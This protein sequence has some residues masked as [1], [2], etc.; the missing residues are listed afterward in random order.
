M[1][2]WCLL[3][4]GIQRLPSRRRHQ[5]TGFKLPFLILF[6]P[7]YRQASFF[8]HPIKIILQIQSPIT[9]SLSVPLSCAFGL[10][11]SA[12]RDDLPRPMGL[13]D[14]SSFSP[15]HLLH[16][17]ETVLYFLFSQHALFYFHY[18]ALSTVCLVA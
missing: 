15:N 5:Q 7:H 8:S 13:E 4:I 9:H 1:D 17:V 10:A 11:E 3:S 18:L 16:Q 12:I 2:P 6:V 14:P